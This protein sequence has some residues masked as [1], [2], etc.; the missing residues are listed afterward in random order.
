VALGTLA[1]R[2]FYGER[3]LRLYELAGATMGTTWHLRLALPEG[4]PGD[5]VEAIGDTVQ[6][7]LDGVE[8]L[9][10]TWDST[11][12]LSRFNRSTDTAATALSPE[13]LEV[14]SIAVEVARAT[15]GA[16]DVTV[17][18]L[19]TAWGFGPDAG[20]GTGNRAP[21][22]EELARL[23]SNVGMAL[24]RV[25]PGRGTAGKARPETRVDL[26][27]VA[28]GYALDRA[29]EGVVR[30]GGDAFAL[31]VGGEVKASGLRPNGA[32]WRVGVEAPIPGERSIVRVIELHDEAVAT[33][34]DYRNIVQV[35]GRTLGHII[36][37]RT[38]A[39]VPWR[40]FS[41][42]VLHREAA[43][44]DAWATALSVL[45]PDEGLQLADSLGIS[46]LFV[47][48]TSA[49]GFE[50]RYTADLRERLEP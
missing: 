17:G 40:G 47:V 39:P 2:T 46:A 45:G 28:K 20:E 6:S 30:M 24:L 23:R 43:R 31:E 18:P 10:S 37:P 29:A 3:T 16:L 21:T 27:A 49:G 12:E 19:V 34:G 22:A 42:S 33:S 41:V 36:D 25:D 7:R 35:D 11:S 48:S 13:T 1:G 15:G 50:E 8:G 4:S 5:W 9:M 32:A 38:G 26:S 44:A 14:L